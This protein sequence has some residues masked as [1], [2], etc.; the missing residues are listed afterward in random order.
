MKFLTIPYLGYSA[1]QQDEDPGADGPVER[2]WKQ[3]INNALRQWRRLP[4]IV[5]NA[6]IP[7]LQVSSEHHRHI[8]YYRF[9]VT[10]E[11]TRVS[12]CL[13]HSLCNNTVSVCS[14][15]GRAARGTADPPRTSAY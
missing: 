14:A 2:L 8:P 11:H 3:A 13:P 12:R 10:L 7:L 15:S 5:S 6:H 9:S 1:L 4:K